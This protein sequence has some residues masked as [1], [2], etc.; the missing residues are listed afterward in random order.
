MPRNQS[1][2]RKV[3]KNPKISEMTIEERMKILDHKNVDDMSEEEL[4]FYIEN[5][6]S[7]MG[8]LS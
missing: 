3:N 7:N 8:L 5:S 4:D 2:K 6:R 1:C